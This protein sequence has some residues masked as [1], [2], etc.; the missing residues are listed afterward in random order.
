MIKVSIIS[1]EFM[2]LLW[3]QKT[4]C[5][6]FISLG[7]NCMVSTAL[8]DNNLRQEAYPFDW[9]VSPFNSLYKAL[10]ENFK[11]F[12]S[13]DSLTIREFDH[14]GVLDSYGFHFVHDFPA[15]LP[16]DSFAELIGENHVT[17][18]ILRDDWRNFIPD[19]Q[20]KYLRRIERLHNL[21]S[22]S[23]TVFL[24]RHGDTT[25]DQAILLRDWLIKKYPN[26]NFTLIILDV[27]ND[28]KENWQL[29][30]II[31]LYLDEKDPEQW[32]VFF[33]TLIN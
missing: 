2:L 13:A 10:D 19:V 30:N 12:L 7:Q 4:D 26:L 33:K 29:N 23:E 28:I 27:C 31:N 5:L 32:K 21:L 11:N 3:I 25:K 9:I 8:R 18:G 1:I 22:S 17:G 15:I 16:N 6:K 14:Y 24:I 20:A